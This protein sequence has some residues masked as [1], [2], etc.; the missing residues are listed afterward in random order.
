MMVGQTITNKHTGE[1]AKIV[2]KELLA[3][4]EFKMMGKLSNLVYV[5]ESENGTLD[6][7]N[8]VYMYNWTT[9]SE[10]E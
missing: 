7:W 9:G 3:G 4:D 6:R 5:L 2:D 10:E 8:A 1:K